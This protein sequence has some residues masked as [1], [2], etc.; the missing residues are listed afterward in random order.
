[1]GHGNARRQHMTDLDYHMTSALPLSQMAMDD[2][3]CDDP[4]S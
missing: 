4:R 2:A 1:M 3:F